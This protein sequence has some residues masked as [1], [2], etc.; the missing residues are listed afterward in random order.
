MTSEGVLKR[1]G[2]ILDLCN[3]SK[4]ISPFLS[5]KGPRSKARHVRI[6]H[7]ILEVLQICEK[8]KHFVPMVLHLQNSCF[9]ST[10]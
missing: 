6:A 5:E 10:C 2:P 3:T 1:K 9:E 7:I 4:L 8:D